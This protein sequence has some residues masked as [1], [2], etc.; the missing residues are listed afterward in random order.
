MACQSHEFPLNQCLRAKGDLSA[1]VSCKE[2]EV[3]QQT[4]CGSSCAGDAAEIKHIPQ[5]TCRKGSQPGDYFKD[6]CTP[7][8][9]TNAT[10][11]S[12]LAESQ[13]AQLM[14]NLHTPKTNGTW[15]QKVCSGDGCTE[16]EKCEVETYNQGQCYPV[17]GGG[18]A[19]GECWTCGVRLSIWSADGCPG[20]PS[21]VRNEPV[22]E[23]AKQQGGSWAMNFCDSPA[24]VT[25]GS[26]GVL[27]LPREDHGVAY[28]NNDHHYE[29]PPC[30]DDEVAARLSNGGGALCASQ[31]GADGSCSHDFPEDVQ[32][33][34]PACALQDKAGN[35]YCALTCGRASGGCPS[36]AHCTSGVCVFPEDGQ[37]QGNFQ[38]LFPAA[39]PDF[40]QL[41]CSDRKCSSQCQP[42]SYT[43]DDCLPV[44]GGGSA[45]GVSCCDNTD[46][47]LAGATFGLVL[48]VFRSDDCTGASQRMK[49]P[50]KE[51]D[52]TSS[53]DN[54]FAKF[55]CGGNSSAS[56]PA[57]TELLLQS[58]ISV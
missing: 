37:L 46:C 3:E 11:A 18:S 30:L 15:S 13:F 1:I 42:E 48:D 12:Q 24:S 50:V 32:N 49:E 20:E 54:K 35:K 41:V 21:Q 53:G 23:C 5:N 44:V 55:V 47:T 38:N 51:C 39:D 14:F 9:S 25:S 34:Q 7:G 2:D 8:S 27:H 29:A 31:C 6:E 43:F 36:G 26:P 40:S 52:R 28:M 45:R 17:E 10:V 58:M 22:G 33:P 57:V 56:R 19:I 4:F 16:E